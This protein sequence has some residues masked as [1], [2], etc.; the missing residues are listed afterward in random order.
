M[1]S[2][3]WIVGWFVIDITQTMQVLKAFVISCFG[4]DF[5]YSHYLIAVDADGVFE[6]VTVPKLE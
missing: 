3:K 6:A 5:T 1:T 4:T 2:F